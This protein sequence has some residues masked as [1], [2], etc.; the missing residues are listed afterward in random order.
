MMSESVPAKFEALICL[1]YSVNALLKFPVFK[2]RR[3]RPWRILL[4]SDSRDMSPEE[5]AALA[6]L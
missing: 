4:C 5:E 3:G 2:G 1:L 6:E